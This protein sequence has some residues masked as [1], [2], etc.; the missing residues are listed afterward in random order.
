MNMQN[1]QSETSGA[2][3]P[4]FCLLP[5]AFLIGLTLA[6]FPR[7]A[8]AQL[9]NVTDPLMVLMQ[10]QPPMITATPKQSLAVFDPPVVR[11]GEEAT[12][13]VT[14]DALSDSINWPDKLPA[15]SGLLLRPSARGQILQQLGG[16]LLPRSVFNHRARSDRPG[17]YL[18]PE[19]TVQAYGRPVTIPAA[20]LEVVPAN[21][22]TSSALTRLQLELPLTNVF[23]GQAVNARVRQSATGPG[24]VPG[25]TQVELIGDGILVDR[26]LT[27]QR[28]EGRPGNPTNLATFVHDT[29]FIPLRAGTITLTGQGFQ[30]A[31]LFGSPTTLT[32]P[33]TIP[34]GLPALSL[35][36]SDPVTITV[37]SLPKEG[38]LP[39]FTGGIGHL[40]IDPPVL[41]T[42]RLRVGE[43][44]KLTITVRGQGNLGRLLPPT[45]QPTGEWQVFSD[46]SETS[47]A[48]IRAR[49]FVTFSYA[50]IPMSTAT[51]STPALPFSYFDPTRATYVDLTIPPVS[52]TVQPGPQPTD[53]QALAFAASQKIG[54]TNEPVLSELAKEP[55][56]T[57]ASLV[58]LALR[59]WFPLA[60]AAPVLGFVGLWTWDRRRRFLEAHPDIMVRRR[61]RRALRQARR[62]LQAAVRKGDAAGVVKFGVEAMRVTAAPHFPAEPRALVGSDVLGLFSDQERQGKFGETV[63]QL[64][65]HADAAQFGTQSPDGRTLLAAHGDIE[66][67]LSRLEAML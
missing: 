65:T 46:N 32:G 37:R 48:L 38:E 27:Q 15:P 2:T 50:L 8:N 24:A 23:A 44:V 61:A 7:T 39:G 12:Y 56:A 31:S 26:S 35:L 18:I 42:N 21:S 40:T 20:R 25:L 41:S 47:P 34:G 57:A 55:G 14:V 29:T 64:F 4:A 66:R 51:R 13:R 22:P 19:F 9:T 36:D 62:E 10:S 17:I 1:A 49:G 54:A 6:F 60:Q 45:P 58:P 5:S 63:R 11:V 43:P 16:T 53:T 59:R 52:V 3:T 28:F 67:M 33:T 30:S